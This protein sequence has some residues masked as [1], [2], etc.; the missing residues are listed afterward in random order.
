MMNSRTL[1]QM[2]KE[3]L[4][5]FGE[6]TGPHY[7]EISKLPGT[8]TTTQNYSRMSCVRCPVSIPIRFELS[9]T[10]LIFSTRQLLGSLVES[11]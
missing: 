5:R 3:D 11:A 1:D 8:N 2:A 4:L 10:I 9:V 7:I 6:I